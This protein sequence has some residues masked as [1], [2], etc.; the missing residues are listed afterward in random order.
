MSAPDVVTKEACPHGHLDT[1]C[2]TCDR[3]WWH[4][5]IARELKRLRDECDSPAFNVPGI[6]GNVRATVSDTRR[7]VAQ[8]VEWGE[9]VPAEPLWNYPETWVAIA[10]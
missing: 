4:E 6:A 7:A 5:A 2:R 8:M 10:P 1:A 9:L 3:Y